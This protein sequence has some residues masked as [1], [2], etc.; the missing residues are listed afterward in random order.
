MP[1][2]YLLL[3]LLKVAFH[4]LCARWQAEETPAPLLAALARTVHVYAAGRVSPRALSLLAL[5]LLFLA[6]CL[7][8]PRC[9]LALEKLPSRC[10]SGKVLLLWAR[11][12]FCWRDKRLMMYSCQPPRPSGTLAHCRPA[13]ESLE[14]IPCSLLKASLQSP[15]CVTLH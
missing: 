1:G 13:A 9:C 4:P 5:Y 15:L 3:E 6:I 2:V 8:R 11:R 10:L 14:K 12:P 7:C